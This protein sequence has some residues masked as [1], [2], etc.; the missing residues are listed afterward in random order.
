MRSPAKDG[1]ARMRGYAAQF[2]EQL[3]RGF[4]TGV[5]LEFP[6][7]TR[8]T[9]W[10]AA[11]MGG[12]A[13][14]SD[15]FAGILARET[16]RT[17]TVHRGPSLPAAVSDRWLAIFTSYSG[18]TWETLAAYDQ[19]GRRSAARLVVSSGG[20]LTERAAEDGVPCLVVPA[21][22][23]PRAALGFLL[24]GL[25]GVFDASFP[26]SNEGRLATVTAELERRIRSLERPAGGPAR[27]ARALGRRSPYVYA[28]EGF[29]ALARRWKTQV[30]ENAKRLA[31]F[32]LLPE[33]L[34]NALVPWERLSAQEAA[35]RAVI[36]LEATGQD[37]RLQLRFRYLGRV[38]KARRVAVHRVPLPG[39]DP[40]LA[41]TTG[42]AWA[43]YLSLALAELASVDPF[44]IRALERMKTALAGR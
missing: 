14:A 41:L 6:V 10:A 4:R 39:P 13:I 38:L 24:G 20:T 40:L 29:S 1:L 33:L 28:E 15:L 12:S 42:V 18:N 35:R 2:P 11:G 19:A 30:E 23:P 36:L 27:L 34:H 26:E 3:R 21:G 32:D 43:D 37:S 16:E 44:E 31:H 9:Y 17:L 7:P 22:L 8:A 25:L 5:D